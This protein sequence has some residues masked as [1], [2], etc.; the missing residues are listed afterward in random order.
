M[1]INCD[2]VLYQLSIDQL[3]AEVEFIVSILD[4]FKIDRT[5]ESLGYFVNKIQTQAFTVVFSTIASP[6]GTLSLLEESRYQQQPNPNPMTHAACPHNQPS[7]PRVLG[8]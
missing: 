7:C 5:L 6:Y 1:L 4:I 2:L 3:D 8:V